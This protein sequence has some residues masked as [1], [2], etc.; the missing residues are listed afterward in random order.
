MKKE[1]GERES[2]LNGERSGLGDGDGVATESLNIE[3]KGKMEH[4]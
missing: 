3:A 4:R 1:E 2:D